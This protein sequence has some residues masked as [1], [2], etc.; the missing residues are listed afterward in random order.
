[1]GVEA[2]ASAASPQAM[3]HMIVMARRARHQTAGP[4][5]ACK[6]TLR[7]GFSAEPHAISVVPREACGLIVVGCCPH[8][9]ALAT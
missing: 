9:L 6:E 2:V 8:A 5:I 3:S 1:M 4:D 7:D